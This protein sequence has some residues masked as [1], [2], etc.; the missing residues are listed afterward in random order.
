MA[1]HVLITGGAGFIGSHLARELLSQGYTVR[2]LDNLSPQVHGCDAKR[3]AYL[4]QDVELVAGDVRSPEAV[5]KA[6]T[7][8]DAVYHFAATVGVGQ[9]MYE[10]RR[11]TEVNNLG[12]ATLLEA[13][14]ERPVER[15]VVASS[16]S[17]YGEGLYRA[18]DGGIVLGSELSLI[19][20]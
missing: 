12:T 8:I 10:I 11:Y 4:D 20:I 3:P 2:V 5:T 14:I 9:S 17:V 6:L 16:M 18:P 13:L 1:K 7:G 19:H 15:L